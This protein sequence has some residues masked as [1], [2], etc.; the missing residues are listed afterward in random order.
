MVINERVCEGCGDCGV[1]SG[2]LSVEPVNTEL[3]RKTQIDQAALQHATTAACDGDC[4]SFVTVTRGGGA[5]VAADRR[6]PTGNCL[7]RTAAVTAAPATGSSPSASAEPAWSPSTRCWP[8]PRSWT[9]G[10][11]TG[12]DQTGL[13]QKA[14]PVVSHLRLVAPVTGGPIVQRGSGEESRRSCCSALDLLVGGRAGHLARLRRPDRDGG[15]TSLVATADMVRGGRAP[16][17]S[18]RCS[19]R[20]RERTRPGG[21]TAVDTRRG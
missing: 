5:P 2:C 6:L 14:G 12:L 10:R 11:S 17:T 16:S 4:P 21:L 3:G 13:S 7:S 1:K 15:L 8:R 19:T 18:A 20:S 9:G